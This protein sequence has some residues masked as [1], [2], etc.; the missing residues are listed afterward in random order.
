MKTRFNSLIILGFISLMLVSCSEDFIS[1]IP[2]SVQTEA[3]YY[4]NIGELESGLYACYSVVNTYWPS[5]WIVSHLPSVLYVIGNIGSDDSE[6]GGDPNPWLW[7]LEA[8]SISV[9]QQTSDNVYLFFWYQINY[10]LIGKCNVVIDKSEDLKGIAEEDDIE[11]IVDQAKYLRAFGFYN[12]VTMYG[13]IPL[14]THW[15]NP[16]ELNLVRSPESLVWEQIE[17]DL[18]DAADLPLKS[19]S[20]LGRATQGAVL[21]LLGKSY[22]WQEKWNLAIEAYTSII[23]SNEYELLPDFGYIH[24]PDGE[25]CRESIF[26]FQEAAG[27]DNGDMV[28]WLGVFRLSRDYGAGGWGFDNPTQDLVN[29]FE[30]GDPRIIYSIIFKGDVFPTPQGDY[31]VENIDSHTGYSDRKAWIPWD[32]RPSGGWPLEINWRYC[33]Y[34]EVLLFCAEALNEDGQPGQARLYLNMVRERARITPKV[35]PERLSCVWD[36][37]YTGELLPD[38]IT[39]DQGQLREAI[40]HEQ[41]VELAM[42]GHRRWILLRTNRFKERME[43]VKGAKGCFVDD[44]ELLFPL[45]TD[46]VDKSQGRIVQNPGYN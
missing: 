46:E 25:H 10:D 44:H 45:P 34:A 26:E 23:E 7:E 2:P 14:P 40:Y 41:R 19:E 43:E 11:K 5:D 15:L 13:D 18:N 20:Q 9:S 17:K 3:N 42:E 30:P 24:H 12:L 6:S 39:N 27:V 8:Y 32:D 21:A 38:V 28:S 22:M 4:K 35:D 1:T 33:R 29:E 37:T 16:D 31:V 36:S